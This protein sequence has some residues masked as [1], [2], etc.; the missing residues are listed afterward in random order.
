M[1][2]LEGRDP[3]WNSAKETEY[4]QCIRRVNLDIMASRAKSTV[5]GH[6]RRI[7][8][9]IKNNLAIGKTTRFPPRGPFE[10]DD[11]IGMGLGVD[12]LQR[13]LHSKGRIGKSPF[14]QWDA[15]R[16]L[17][18]TFTKT[19]DSSPVGISEGSSFA[20]NASKIRF[21]SCPSQSVAFGDFLAGAEDRM[22]YDTRKQLYLRMPTIIEQLRLIRR[23]AASAEPPE[24]N[25]LYRLGALITILTAASLRGHEGL[26]FD[27]AATRKYL[28]QGRHGTI[29]DK[30]LKRPVLTE[31]ECSNLP[32]VCLC[33]IG[34]FKGETGERH[35]SIVL[36]NTSVSGLE[37]RWWIE[38]LLEVCA[39]EGRV[40]GYA[41]KD[42]TNTLPTS[43]DYNAMVRQYLKEI[44]STRP[45]LFDE[46]EDLIRYGISRTYRKSSETRARRAGLKDEDVKEVN[47]W[48]TTEQA[49]GKKPR[50]AMID[51]YSDARGL[52]TKTWRY[53]YAL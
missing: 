37:P 16:D 34:K 23:D 43:A 20:G 1:R 42:D 6:V 7:R 46:K 32:E 12:L 25:S 31:E 22:G 40:S 39:S 48:K 27:I 45:D 51:H 19:W 5:D 13:S 14:I 47:R 29:P 24:S 49:K 2:N 44:Q 38:K 8:D 30:V 50:H 28:E 17:R 3:D 52:A 11:T 15:M 9:T 26:Y 53:S 35:H 4:L 41:F 36:A 33:L 18:S 21:T 10:L